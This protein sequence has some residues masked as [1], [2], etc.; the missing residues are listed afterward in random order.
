MWSSGP[1]ATIN[2]EFYIIPP[3]TIGPKS[4]DISAL[5]G[6]V[7]LSATASLTFDLKATLDATSGSVSVK[8]PVNAYVDL[9]TSVTPGD[10]FTIGTQ[11]FSTATP[12]L[13]T[14]FP[15]LTFSVVFDASATLTGSL[16]T[17]FGDTDFD[18]TPIFD[19]HQPLYTLSTGGASKDF[20]AEDSF[21]T[22]NDPAL[23]KLASGA[24]TLTAALPN[25]FA[26]ESTS[27]DPATFGTM[28]SVTSTGTSND[29]LTVSADLVKIAALFGGIPPALVSGDLTIGNT[30]FGEYDLASIVLSAGLQIAQKFTF[31]PTAIDVTIDPGFGDAQVKTGKLGDSFTFT[32]PANWSG[33]VHPTATYSLE[34]NLISDTG[35]LG[36]A[37]L[38]VSAGRFKLQAFYG[39]GKS[40]GI[41]LGPVVSD[42]V[43]L[44]TSN[45]RYLI[46]PGTG[47][48]PDASFKFDSFNT[49]SAGYTIPVA[50]VPVQIVL[51]ST[52]TS[53]QG[54]DMSNPNNW[55]PQLD[56]AHPVLPTGSNAV[57]PGG[58]WSGTISL[59]SIQLGVGTNATLVG[60]LT[61]FTS[62]IEGTLTINDPNA[63]LQGTIT[64]FLGGVI[65]LNDGTVSGGLSVGDNGSGRVVQN[66]GTVTASIEIGVQGQ[67]AGVY[68]VKGGVVHAAQIWVGEHGTGTI[69]QSGGDVSY[70]VAGASTV[71]VITLG[72]Y[73]DGE[74][75]YL[76]QAGT[77]TAAVMEVGQAGIGL[78]VQ[79]G[80]SATVADVLVGMDGNGTYQLHHGSLTVSSIN[81]GGHDGIGTGDAGYG[82]FNFNTEAGDDATLVLGQG[83]SFSQNGALVVGNLGTGVFNQGGGTLIAPT[84]I[85][86]AKNFL[87]D[88]GPSEGRY[89][90]VGGTLI[91][92][93]NETVGSS[94]SGFFIQYGGTN[95]ITDPTYSF[96]HPDTPF[97][98][99][100][101]V[102]GVST[103]LSAYGSY[104]LQKGILS[105][106]ANEVIGYGGRGEFTQT[107]GSNSTGTLI[108]GLFGVEG[109]SY[110]QH[111]GTLAAAYEYIGYGS[112]GEFIQSDGVNTVG[113]GTVDESGA[114]VILG[115]TSP[116]TYTLGGTGALDIT[117]GLTVGFRAKGSLFEWNVEDGDNATLSI[118]QGLVVG[119]KA[120]NATFVQ[121]GGKLVLQSLDVAKTI[122]ASGDYQLYG[123]PQSDQLTVTGTENIGAAG[124][125]ATFEQEG[126][127]NTT[128]LLV[129]GNA[130][131]YLD[132]GTLKAGAEKIGTI[133]TG[134]FDQT[135][136]LNTVTGD[137]TIGQA[138]AFATGTYSLGGDGKLNV[139]GAVVI[140]NGAFYFN[141]QP[142]DIALFTPGA[143]L[144]VIGENQFGTA[145]FVQ[146]GGTLETSIEIG[147]NAGSAGTFK[148]L[149]GTLNA[150]S[151]ALHDGSVKVGDAGQGNF[152]HTGLLAE[153]AGTLDIGVQAS[154]LGTY[155]LV[156]G[157]LDAESE[158]IGDGGNGSLIESGGKN[159]VSGAISVGKQAGSTGLFSVI[160]GSA[161]AASLSIGGK[162]TVVVG[163]DSVVDAGELMMTGGTIDV[164]GGALTSAGSG[165]GSLTVG[166]STH[167]IAATVHVGS[168]ASFVGFGTIGGNLVV[169]GSV[170]IAGGALIV[171]GAV[172]GSTSPQIDS[173]AALVIGG[174][175]QGS[176]LFNGGANTTLK[177]LQPAGFTGQIK[178]LAAGNVIDLA[179]KSVTEA[180]IKA[181]AGTYVLD[182]STNTSEHFTFNI[183][184]ALAGS[185]FKISADGQGGSNLTLVAGPPV[186][187]I[188]A[189]DASKPE[190][191]T[192]TTT[193]TFGLTLH[194]D[195][196]VA[197]SVSWAV[198]G[199][200]ANPATAQDFAGGVLPAGTIAFQPGET[201]KTISIG[202][203]GD[204]VVEPDEGFTVSLSNPSS[205]LSVGTGSANGAILNDDK[206]AVTVSTHDDAYVVQQGQSLSN[207]TSVLANDTGATTAS[208][209]V[210][211]TH[212][213]LQLAADGSFGY[214][215]AAS[216]NGIDTFTYHA[217][218]GSS[219]A[220]G[221]AEIYV[222]PTLTGGGATTL[223]LLALNA[224]EQIASTYAA[225]FGRGADAAGFAFWV[226]QFNTGLPTQ[227]A[228]ALFANI[229]SSFGISTEA[230]ALYPFLANPFGASDGQIG[231]FVD[232]VYNNL[233]NRGSDAP[234]LAYWTGQIKATLAGGQF[235]GSVLINM[236]SGA[237][238]TAVGKDITTLMGKVAVSLAYVQDQQ[239]HNTAW[240]GASD[241]AAATNLL[242]GVTSD[243][244]TIL[245]GIKNADWLIANHA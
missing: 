208:L 120:Q 191:G 23:I 168:G 117:G 239:E 30:K 38:S 150:G 125:Q 166:D 124:G 172:T 63:L 59:G 83:Q 143:H 185:T 195:N 29:I 24:V 170:E 138:L 118:S 10:S 127:A 134:E 224:E 178:G 72:R 21:K 174:L 196:S 115:N 153:I 54:G 145:L 4:V 109:G 220:D 219:A 212:G 126:A 242:H 136:G 5:G 28:A 231:A 105:V 198:T 142:N 205:D 206:A 235:V 180:T 238:D 154:G 216:F 146:V 240:A 128:S 184:G 192:G 222:V 35:V 64:I 87:T 67:S 161:S 15:G 152:T 70:L 6:L 160:G 203:A 91:S 1:A 110:K 55:G 144:V 37:D 108:L 173:G 39:N 41:D 85:V 210:G 228:A 131:Y 132:E 69:V 217:S 245:T 233:F 49:I 90:L 121:G 139:S 241:I 179:K 181:G 103:N 100:G 8:Y 92:K 218:N 94:G 46:N 171:T 22:N 40:L 43:N 230:K 107:G 197:H 157:I 243:P 207:A 56:P 26:T 53:F 190:G 151:A 229:A 11:Y 12:D 74:G 167:A 73:F 76:F 114:A 221:Q 102:L 199:A 201:S 68:E 9:P 48:S 88:G 99:R 188:G 226:D 213:A 34:G 111:A 116:G 186:V 141:P 14:T 60:K 51:P 98:G 123:D 82:V 96:A 244:Q 133:G 164:L 204:T 33:P 159:T 129:V 58:T 232:S 44:F 158:I 16:K 209:L 77:I 177:L 19:I 27:L 193:F 182:V 122:F 234:G 75:T 95:S 149:D 57:M 223:N 237:Q 7:S 36:H 112:P 32:T 2:T 17:P 227:G 163:S 135:G 187:D 31:Q 3:Q 45:P 176:V 71:G 202:V 62:F 93:G 155:S 80:G 79:S 101:L 20:D 104:Q 225:F 137:L 175:E 214:T 81:L 65:V 169:D 106:A 89:S 194:G 189:I 148:F 147:Q 200:G 25:P 84:G 162:G 183:D 97:D 78:F 236:M 47:T 61:T 165:T 42:S 215:P 113:N 13:K 66:K 18:Y 50:T 211:A 130:T 140:D 52:T 156:S 119:Y 86:L